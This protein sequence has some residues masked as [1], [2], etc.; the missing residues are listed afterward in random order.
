VTTN[1]CFPS[2]ATKVHFRG[3]AVKINQTLGLLRVSTDDKK[4]KSI[5]EN[6]G[7]FRGPE[8]TP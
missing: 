2:K 6:N 5:Q 8:Y 3:G 7:R 1:D 4:E